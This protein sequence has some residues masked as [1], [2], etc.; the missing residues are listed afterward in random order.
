MHTKRTSP[1]SDLLKRFNDALKRPH[2]WHITGVD[3]FWLEDT[4]GVVLT[5]EFLDTPPIYDAVLAAV[6]A[7]ADPETIVLVGRTPTGR[8][9]VL[10][11]GLNLLDMA[12]AHAGIPARRRVST[13]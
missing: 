12:E 7:G 13:E 8:R 11:V 9:S 6:G 3:A 10:G 2:T 5:A 1:S 4:S